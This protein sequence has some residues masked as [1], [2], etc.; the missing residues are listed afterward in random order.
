M[1]VQ[2]QRIVWALGLGVFLPCLALWAFGFNFDQRG[3]PLGG[4]VIVCTAITMVVYFMGPWDELQQ[5]EDRLVQ[6][7]ADRM[8]R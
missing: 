8:S 3:I 5:R 1:R 2:Q 7:I 4:L 6:D